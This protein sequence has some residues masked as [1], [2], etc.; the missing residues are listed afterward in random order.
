MKNSRK[1]DKIPDCN[2]CIGSKL[3][4]VNIAFIVL[5][6]PIKPNQSVQQMTP[7]VSIII[8]QNNIR[9]AHERCRTFG[10]GAL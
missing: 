10:S 2:T 1:N 3:Q 6:V 9:S 7:Q 5:K 8:V 4:S